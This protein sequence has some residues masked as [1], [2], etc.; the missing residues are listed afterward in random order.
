MRNLLINNLRYVVK[1]GDGSL[2]GV[3]VKFKSGLNVIFGPNSVGKTSIIIG[4]LYGL[5]AEKGLGI[6][7]KQQ[8]FKPEF[9]KNI[10][11]KDITES[12]LLLEVGNGVKN[13]TIKR[14]IA[15]D[16]STCIIKECEFNNFDSMSHGKKLIA[17]GK[18]VM[19]EE[20]LQNYLFRFFGW[21]NVE[22]SKYDGGVS[23]LYIENLL[24]L[25]FIEQRAGWSQIQARQVMQYGI[26][27]IKNV[28]FEYLMGLDKFDVHNVQMKIKEIE[29]KVAEKQNDITCKENN[30]FIFANASKDENNHL[31]VEMPGSGKYEIKR[32]ISALR[33]ELEKKESET[34]KLDEKLAKNDVIE[35]KQR[36][37]IRRTIQLRLAASEKVKHLEREISSYQNYIS[38]ID[39]NRKKNQ[40][41]KRI[42]Q[43]ASD[44]NISICPVCQARLPHG[45]HGTCKLCKSDIPHTSTPEDNLAFL[46]DERSS[47]VNILSDR[48]LDF[49]KAKKSLHDLEEKE[50]TLKDRLD[51]H[52]KTYYGESLEAVRA[53]TDKSDEIFRSI[54]RYSGILNQWNSLTPLRTEVEELRRRKDE[55]KAQ[56]KKYIESTSDKD[57]IA[58]LLRCFKENVVKLKLFKANEEL[59]NELRLDEGSNYTPYLPSDDLYNISSSS[60]SIRIIL[61]YYLSLLQT[62]I[63]IDTQ[64]I[65]FPGLLIMDEPKQQ[66]LNEDE[67]KTFVSTAESIPE[68]KMWQIILTTNTKDKSYLG[69][70]IVKEMIGNKDFLLK[71][72]N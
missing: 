36:D 65:R 51:Y 1:C 57:I 7:S 49:E 44:L 16:S 4:I 42:N 41:L 25:F 46:E 12:Y 23:E 60:D 18:G 21:E 54:E 52:M 68:N 35:N 47:F 15:G 5:G 24:P 17:E 66:N 40:Q 30:I 64:K 8:P 14:P 59:T 67:I 37:E 9:Y 28:A 43:I 32:L 71:R 53:S 29:S 39:I 26:R 72:I 58:T 33:S 31:I 55:L 10:E 38:R 3:T 56:V 48:E 63:A 34:S 69:N 45:E 62:A 2:Y 61:S 13:I 70:H 19:S 50:A 27:D 22:V 6:F 11:G 20:G